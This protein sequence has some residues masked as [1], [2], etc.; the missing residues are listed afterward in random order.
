MSE[1]TACKESLNN[2]FTMS[3]SNGYTVSVRWG[4][5]NYCDNRVVYADHNKQY[6]C[7][8]SPNAE[9][10]VWNSNG[11]FVQAPDVKGDVWAFQTTEEVALLVFQV[12]NWS[13]E[14]ANGNKR[15]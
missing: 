15:S 10:A 12:A 7:T 6:N 1:F 9:V 4:Y 8:T 14:L 11:D 3:F 2:G 5:G 13:K